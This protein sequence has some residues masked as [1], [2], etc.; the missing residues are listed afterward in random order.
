MS[1]IQTIRDKY[2]RLA[3]IA[4]AVAL[5]GFILID[6]ISGRGRSLFNGGS[7]TLGS[8]NGKKIDELEFEKKVQMQEQGQQQGTV[9]EEGRQ[10]LIAALW[11]Q[12][13]D[14]ILLKEEFDRLG[15]SVGK[16]EFGDML[17]NEPHQ[18]ARQYLGNPQN[19]QYDP[20]YVRQL[21]NSISRGKDK[22]QKE[23][24]NL[25]LDAIEKAR[26]IEKYEGLV[27]GAIHY[28][29]WLFEKQNTDNSL[30]GKISYVSV[31]NSTISDS[32][33]EVAVSDQEIENYISKHKD[34]YKAE[35]ES[36][37][38]QY[39]LFSAAPSSS[40]SAATYKTVSQLKEK[41][42]TTNDSAALK[43][44]LAGESDFA[45][46]D[47]YFSKSTIQVPAKDTI[48][49]LGKNEVYGPYLD[50]AD[51]VVA[52]KVDEK[53]LP[54]SVYCRHIL[55]RTSGDGALPDSIAEKRIDSVIAAINS[56][57]NFISVMKKVSMD[58]AANS[59][60]STG[61]MKFSAQQIQDAQR[62]DQDFGKY[63]LF[64]GVKDQRKKVKTQF[65]YHYIE[66]VDQKNFEPHYKVAYL[67]KR[68]EAS[69]ETDR[70]AENAALQFAGNSRDLKTFDANAEKDLKPKG[71]QKLI[72]PNI[73]AHAF[74]IPG[75]GVS[76]KF[77]KDIFDADRGDVIK[78]DGKVGD[79]YVVAAVTQINKAGTYT[80]ANGRSYIEPIL[81]NK[82][83]ADE[84]KR[85]IGKVTTLDAVATSM[86]Q[87]IQTA[88]SLRFSGSGRSPVSFEHKVL[89]AT[90]NPANKG[91]V[92][93]EAL[94]GT[95]AVYVV[96]VDDVSATIVENADVAAQQKNLESQG[97]MRILMGNQYSQFGYGQYDPAA[98][99]RKAAT[100]KDNRSRFY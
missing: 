40:D 94:D 24:L 19:G 6:Y 85:R 74:E 23:Q 63:I 20:T 12:E 16:K 55:I 41:L 68:I 52:K 7:T 50:G 5:V 81:K 84:I 70:N 4:V 65:G 97:R 93:P 46:S 34:T 75:I 1:I 77:I 47:T 90:F 53:S 59:Q 42:A 38:I 56:G 45:F 89:G 78:S 32:A 100:I 30:L 87:T 86:K 72:A 8:V 76:R 91:K 54:D 82:K 17:Y 62:F 60:D 29:K 44:F 71:I 61:I 36:R 58:Q 66:I 22:N 73:N 25:V 92:V 10:Q 18:L 95:A 39:V 11:K 83:K 49:K 57:A 51:Y 13:V 21:I 67:A 37:T 48:F 88:D 98:V 96:K 9:G 2:A 80:A 99:L 3:V 31:P 64:D 69:D 15:L 35:D 43:T 79:N 26:L 33:K 27:A 28:P 14:Q